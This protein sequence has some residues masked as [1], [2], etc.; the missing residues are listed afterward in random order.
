[1]RLQ[2]KRKIESHESTRLTG[3]PIAHRGIVFIPVASWE[4]TR[5]INPDYQCC[6][7]RGSLVALRI[8]DGSL[9]WKAYTVGEPKETGSSKVGTPN[10]GPSGAGIWSAPTLDPERDLIYVTTGNNYSSPATNTSDAVLAFHIYTGQMVWAR[11]LR[12]GDAFNSSCGRGPN[13]PKES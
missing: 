1:G 3:A 2:W 8:R 9:V 11:Q 10:W 7:F 5:A 13:C 12:P 4:E 6:T